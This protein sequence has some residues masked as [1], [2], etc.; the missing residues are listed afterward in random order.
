MSKLPK[1]PQTPSPS[2]DADPRALWGIDAGAFILGSLALLLLSRF[3]ILISLPF[4]L[5]LMAG[6]AAVF[7]AEIVLWYRR[8]VRRVRVESDALV[9]EGR[10]GSPPR[11]FS[12]REIRGVRRTRRLGGGRILIR[13]EAPAL[14]PW[15]RLLPAFMRGRLALRSELFSPGDFT[16]MYQEIS[17]LASRR[18]SLL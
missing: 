5:V 7:A 3:R 8:G 16:A 15:T 17:R 18:I 1:T 2:W 12:A 6:M 10:P 11:C 9:L 14:P 13:V 4:A